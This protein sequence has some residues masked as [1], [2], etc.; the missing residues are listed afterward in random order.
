MRHEPIVT[1]RQTLWFLLAYVAII[2]LSVWVNLA[3]FCSGALK[4]DNGCGGAG[5]YIPLW[6]IFLAPLAIA[7]IVLERW[8]RTAPTPASTIVI[9]LVG[10]AV[11]YQVGWQLERFPV[12]LVVEAAAI[13]I[14]TAARWKLTRSRLA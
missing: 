5:T 14:A 6:E 12:L 10:I 4:Y 11:I 13:A 2:A 7:A 9:Y 3:V 8:R 1:A